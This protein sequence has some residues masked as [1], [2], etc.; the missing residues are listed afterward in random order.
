MEATTMNSM[1]TTSGSF[2]GPEVLG[3]SVAA[4]RDANGI[5]LTWSDDFVI[6][7]AP[8]PHWQVVD[9]A[10]NAYLLQRLQTAGDRVNRSVRVPA[11]VRQVSQVRIYCAFAEV[12]LG[13]ASFPSPVM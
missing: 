13:E 3:G 4:M 6:P 9:A 2:D 8:A 12:V 1:S 10:G 11:Y 7:M 5:T